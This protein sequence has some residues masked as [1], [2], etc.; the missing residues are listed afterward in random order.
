[1]NSFNI[2]KDWFQKT[3]LFLMIIKHIRKVPKPLVLY[4]AQD[5]CSYE[6]DLRWLTCNIIN[7]EKCQYQT[8]ELCSVAVNASGWNLRFIN[9]KFINHPIYADLCKSAVKQTGWILNYIKKEFISNEHLQ[10]IYRIAIKNNGVAIQWIP[11]TEL[12][13]EK[14]AKKAVKKSPSVILFVYEY[15]SHF[16]CEFSQEAQ[17]TA[18]FNFCAS[19]VKETGSI[20]RHIKPETLP[21]YELCKIAVTENGRNLTYIENQTEELCILAI[22]QTADAFYFVQRPTQYIYLEL[23][24]NYGLCLRFIKKQTA[25]LCWISVKKNPYS[26][27]EVDEKFLTRELSLA[28]VELDRGVARYVKPEFNDILLIHY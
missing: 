18:F 11:Y 10:K 22:K 27:I 14:F 26:L 13:Y 1:M 25:E 6:Q 8:A 4:I 9:K 28:A 21:Y 7:L 24:K 20:L 2:K 12:N 3:T 16:S 15:F 5:I 17:R 23:V 19:I